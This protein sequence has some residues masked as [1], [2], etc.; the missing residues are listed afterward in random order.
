MRKVVIILIAL[1][2]LPCAAK[3]KDKSTQPAATRVEISDADKRRLSYYFIEGTKQKLADN[4]S[5]AHDLFR[6]CLSIDPTSP[7]ALYELAYMNY[8][9]QRDSVGLA[10]F[11]KASELDADNPW[12]MET[13]AA[14]YLEAGDKQ[15]T[16]P[17]LE[18]L[19]KIQ[20]KRT[21][22]LYQLAE[23]YKNEGDALKCIHALDRIEVL[24][25]RSLSTTMQKYNLYRSI[26]KK[27]EAFA[28]LASLEEEFP[29]DLRIPLF[30]GREYLA[31]GDKQ[32]ALDCYET[33]RKADPDNASLQVAMM[34]YLR[35]EGQ[36]SLCSALRDSLMFSPQTS[37]DIRI[38]LLS[39]MIDEV[40]GNDEGKENALQV[41][42]SL[43][44]LYP[45][46]EAYTMRATF[47]AYI[48]A[49][50]DSLAMALRDLLRVDPS[51][52]LAIRHL[53]PYY[54]HEK[55]NE[56]AIEICRIGINSY[57]EELSYHYFLGAVLYNSDR[58]DDA[59]E[60]FQNG[61]RQVDDDSQPSLVADLYYVLG[62]C[63]HERGDTA[64]AYATYEK[65]LSYDEDNASCLN[66]YSYYLSLQ[67]EQLDKA[68]QMAYRA[69][70]L[71]PLNK[72]F[73]DTY[74]WV[75]FRIGNLS[76][77]KFYID[78]VIPPSADDQTLLDDEELRAEVIRHAADIYRA[79]ELEDEAQRYD[80]LA[81]EKEKTEKDK[82][83]PVETVEPVPEEVDD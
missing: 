46:P 6:H 41:L 45:T 36:D 30:L 82:E 24:E 31:D 33:V 16:I 42:D 14:A 3:K 10:M 81:D 23:L 15:A 25:G 58:L 63:Y 52:Q 29:R 71:E 64:E 59:I 48:D 2:S 34:E 51:N 75:L 72:T 21:D 18:R 4:Y 39:D 17:V 27:K 56:N 32:K 8:Y 7:E 38:S 66:N 61:L 62:D 69:I 74:A 12:Y 77:A 54:I 76:M 9:L 57:P 43:T 1:A 65:C 53:L 5:A 68:E 26:K 40:K 60:A 83:K 13:L 19:A 37:T 67:G 28:E 20:T 80:K 79:N 44:R 47:F 70:K 78:R 50:Q 73:L 22:I 35:H 49:S 11:R 55:D